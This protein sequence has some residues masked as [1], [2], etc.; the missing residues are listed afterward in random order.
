M[1]ILYVLIPLSVV[2]AILIGAV[3][4]GLL[5]FAYVIYTLNVAQYLVQHASA[6]GP[7]KAVPAT[8]DT[9]VAA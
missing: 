5:V 6:H 4:A 1:D 7:A 2:L 8:S 9:D 3:V